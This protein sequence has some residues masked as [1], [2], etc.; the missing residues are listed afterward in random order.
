M[1]QILQAVNLACLLE[2]FQAQRMEA[3][4]VLAAS[5]QDLIRLGVSTIGD[6]IRLRDACRKKVEEN[7]ASTSQA[8]TSTSQANAAQGGTSFNFSSTAT[9]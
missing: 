9:Q 5:D 6:R 1:E 7:A 2:R 4:S 3:D 8:S